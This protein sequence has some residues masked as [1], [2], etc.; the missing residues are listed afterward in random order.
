MCLLVAPADDVEAGCHLSD[1]L[2]SRNNTSEYLVYNY[3]D[4]EKNML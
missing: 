2:I 1:C 3:K 4:K